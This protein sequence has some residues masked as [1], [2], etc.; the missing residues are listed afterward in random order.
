MPEEKD[1]QDIYEGAEHGRAL[2][3]DP[4]QLVQAARHLHGADQ[5]KE[6]KNCNREQA[7]D[8]KVE[9]EKNIRE[10]DNNL[11]GMK[12]EVLFGGANVVG[13]QEMGRRGKEGC[14]GISR[15]SEM[16]SEQL[17]MSRMFAG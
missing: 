7:L 10:P 4:S 2:V 16:M 13:P 11:Q 12:D 17:T 6:T 15:Q 1:Q 14:S 3:E 8:E 9:E 5:T